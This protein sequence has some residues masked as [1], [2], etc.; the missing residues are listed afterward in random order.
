MGHLLSVFLLFVASGTIYLV[1][2]QFQSKLTRF[3]FQRKHDCYP[4]SPMPQRERIIGWDLLQENRTNERNRTLLANGQRRFQKYGNTISNVLGTVPIFSTIEP[5][6]IKTIMATKF[7]DFDIGAMRTRAFGPLLG[8]GIFT[9]DG[10][11]WQHSRSLIRPSFSK[12]QIADLECLDQHVNAMLALIPKDGTTTIDL[13]D[14]FFRLS[15]DMATDTL[16]G[17]SIGSLDPGSIGNQKFQQ[18]FDAFTYSQVCLMRRAQ[19][20]GLVALFRDSKFDES[21]KICRE[22]VD[23]FV[24]QAIEY[25]TSI[26]NPSSKEGERLVD[27]NREEKYVF[28][29]ELAKHTTNPQRLRDEGM[30]MLLAGRDTTS[31]LLA[32]LWHVLARRPDVFQELQEEVK[33]LHGERPT[34]TSMKGMKYLGFCLKETLRLYPSVPVNGRVANKNTFLPLGGGPDGKSRLFIC[35]GQLVTYSLYALHRRKDIFGADAEEFKPE[36]WATLRPGWAYLPFSGGPRIC[37]GQQFALTEA[38]YCTIRLLQSFSRLESRDTLPWEES[39]TITVCSANGVQV[40][41]KP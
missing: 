24:R 4:A 13:Q 38:S 33:Q 31:S 5:E 6:N 7:A 11:L 32:N 40:C 26:E 19:L 37:V 17:S 3:Y 28:L 22:V 16:F 25:N 29:R 36:R 39:L 10:Q 2:L 34:I 21:N 15:L 1:T 9:N 30:C 35:K 12:D 20:G 41:L 23:S 18:F 14:L 27:V 8:N